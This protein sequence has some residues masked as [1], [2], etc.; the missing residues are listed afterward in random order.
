MAVGSETQFA[1][2]NERT[3]EVTTSKVRVETE[4]SWKNL[5]STLKTFYQIFWEA[6]EKIKQESL[7]NLEV[8]R[9]KLR[10]RFSFVYFVPQDD[11]HSVSVKSGKGVS[12]DQRKVLPK[13]IA[14]FSTSHDLFSIYAQLP[15]DNLQLPCHILQI[16]CIFK[17]I[18]QKK[19][20]RQ[21]RIFKRIFA[22]ITNIWN[23][24][25]AFFFC[26]TQMRRKQKQ[27][28]VINKKSK[29]RRKTVVFLSTLS[30]VTTGNHMQYH[31]NPKINKR[32]KQTRKSCKAC[33][34]TRNTMKDMDFRKWK[35]CWGL[36]KKSNIKAC[37][38]RMTQH[39]GEQKQREKLL[40]CRPSRCMDVEL[41]W[42]EVLLNYSVPRCTTKRL[43]TLFSAVRKLDSS[44]KSDKTSSH[45]VIFICFFSLKDAQEE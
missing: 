20:S 14:T 27:M 25:S 35:R 33:Y 43:S 31:R 15:D 22:W 6:V 45:R 11:D 29:S 21:R 7:L 1:E 28:H 2:N 37:K 30:S 26:H 18:Q 13:R 24:I 10:D 12:I 16:T 44:K 5:Q 9:R 17:D 42:Q 38:E 39:L 8:S 3:K 40:S 36:E 34:S 19:Q 23:K 4:G 41:L 32:S